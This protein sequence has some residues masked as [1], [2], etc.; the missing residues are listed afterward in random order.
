LNH[1]ILVASDKY[2]GSLSAFR[3]CTIIKDAILSINKNIEVICSPMADGGEG[4]VETL[5]ESQEGRFIDSEVTGPL[6]QPVTARFGMIKDNIAVIEMASASG[7]VLVPEGSRDPMETTTY[8][9]GELI[10]KAL[11]MGALKIIIGIGGSATNDGGMGMA[12][13]LGVKFFDSGGRLLGHGRKS[14][15]KLARIDAA[16]IHSAVSN[17]KFE[18]ASDVD[19][20]LT[21]KNGAAFVYGPQKGADKNMVRALDRG[22]S[23][24][25]GVIRK[26]LGKDIENLKGAGAAGGLGAGLVAFLG[27]ELVPGTDIVIDITGLEDKIKDTGLVITGEGAM[28]RQTFFGKSAYG[29]AR[30]AKKYSKTVITING[31]V[32]AFRG[33]LNREH[34]SLFNGNFSIINKPMILEEAMDSAEKL[35]REATTEIINFYLSVKQD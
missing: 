22:L 32:F 30:L 31:S 26:D 10:R 33:D 14:L 20:P 17:C 18:V 12:Q 16:G 24:F 5:V 25:A 13:A 29:V 19:N 7:L 21:G 9:T 11:E 35:L 8:G 4:T 27:G 6:G 1:K 3:V 34:S 28:D 15:Q 23:N 2:K